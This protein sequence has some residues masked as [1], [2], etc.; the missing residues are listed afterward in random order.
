MYIPPHYL[1]QDPEKLLSFIRTYPF[2]TLVSTQENR[3]CATHLPF[4]ANA[5]EEGKLVLHSHMAR[6]NS[7]WKNLVGQEVLVIFQEPHAYISPSFYNKPLNVPTWNYAVVHAYGQVKLIEASAAVFEVLENMI[8]NN[9]P[10]Y[11]TQWQQLPLEYKERM[12]RGI[13]AFEVEVTE[14]QGKEKLSQNKA[15]DERHRIAENLKQSTN[16]A[17]ASLGHLMDSTFSPQN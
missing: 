9:E 15:L 3:P 4:T 5:S 16:T 8:I 14:L 6:A 1:Q 2:A 7:Q 12:A 10:T 11:L 17:V 13:V